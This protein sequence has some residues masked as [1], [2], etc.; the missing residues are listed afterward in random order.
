MKILLSILMAAM[1]STSLVAADKLHKAQLQSDMRLML[2][3]LVDL[4]RAGFYNYKD[5]LLVSVKNLKSGL[6]SLK[7]VDAKSY[8]PKEHQNAERFA[9]KRVDMIEMYAD[10]LVISVE[11]DNMDDAF[12]DFVN[13][14]KQ[15][16]SCHLR[17]RKEF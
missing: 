8:L 1:M 2:N 4:Q 11:S 16:T 9:K 7:S 6:K 13:L 10:D 17:L 5:G 14:Q 12:E 15:C 3:S